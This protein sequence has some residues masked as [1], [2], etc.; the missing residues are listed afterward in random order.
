M[1]SIV[2]KHQVFLGL[3]G[4][5]YARIKR[6][7][8]MEQ[9]DWDLFI[10][11]LVRSYDPKHVTVVVDG[12][13]SEGKK[14]TLKSFV[15]SLMLLDT[16]HKREKARQACIQK[17]ERAT[18]EWTRIKPGRMKKLKSWSF[19]AFK[20]RQEHRQ[21]VVDALKTTYTVVEAKGEADVA[22]AKAALRIKTGVA[23]I[24]RD[25]DFFFV[26]GVSNILEPY[27]DRRRRQT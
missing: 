7:A 26:R 3:F 24:S 22:I 25:S 20:L 14:G 18:G 2:G 5:C 4:S 21:A 13:P 23:V 27:W 10:Q 9:P 1:A 11:E 16:H 17:I 8:M 12:M 15:Q 19:G 6:V